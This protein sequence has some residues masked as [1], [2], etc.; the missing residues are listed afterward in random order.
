MKPRDTAFVPESSSSSDSDEDWNPIQEQQNSR[1]KA[2]RGARKNCPPPLTHE[3]T[4]EL[5]KRANTEVVS[6]KH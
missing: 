2:R 1:P 3:Q 4:L 6:T 5:I